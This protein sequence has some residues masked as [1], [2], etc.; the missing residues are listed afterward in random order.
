MK[1]ES[2]PLRVLLVEDTKLVAEQVCE[3]IKGISSGADVTVVTSEHDALTA[4]IELGPDVAIL[5]LSLKQGTGFGVLRA[6]AKI[7]DKPVVV[8]LTNY[9]LP[10]YREFALLL[11]AD[12][13]LDKAKDFEKLPP[14][15]E[16]VA[17]KRVTHITTH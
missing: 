9:A 2:T 13:F 14:L 10:K 1:I 7:V 6:L 12:Y 11:G 16:S 8:V 15:L 5:D 17:R 3:L 4:A